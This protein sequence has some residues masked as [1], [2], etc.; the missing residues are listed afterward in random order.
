MWNVLGALLNV[1]FTIS[2]WLPPHKEQETDPVDE[3][4]TS[5]IVND[6]RSP[7]PPKDPDMAVMSQLAKGMN[8]RHSDNTIDSEVMG[9]VDWKARV[10]PVT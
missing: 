4:H 5:V 10:A 9:Q 1:L 8:L 3:E 2:F 7:I 6:I